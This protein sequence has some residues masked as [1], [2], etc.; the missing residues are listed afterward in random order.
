MDGKGVIIAS[1]DP[2]IVGTYHE[3]AA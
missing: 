2:A 3:V 1:R